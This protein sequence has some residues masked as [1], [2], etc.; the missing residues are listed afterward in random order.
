MA[1]GAPNAALPRRRPHDPGA[2]RGGHLPLQRYRLGAPVAAGNGG[3]TGD[4]GH[5]SAGSRE[6]PALRIAPAHEIGDASAGQ[7]RRLWYCLRAPAATEEQLASL[8][9]LSLNVLA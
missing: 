3:G 5:G 4:C 2:V 1:M 8:R 6:M 7:V 9:R